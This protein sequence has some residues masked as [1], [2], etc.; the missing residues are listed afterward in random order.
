MC[1]SIV[2]GLDANLLCFILDVDKILKPEPIIKYSN[3]PIKLKRKT[4]SKDPKQF[5]IT[6]HSKG[7]IDENR[8]RLYVDGLLPTAKWVIHD[9]TPLDSDRQIYLITSESLIGLFKKI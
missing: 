4:R 7:K 9:M 1:L 8:L 5:T 3:V 6:V 2:K